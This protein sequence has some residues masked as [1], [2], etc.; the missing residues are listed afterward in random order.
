MKIFSV[1]FLFL[2]VMGCFGESGKDMFEV[3]IKDHEEAIGY[4]SKANISIEA[5][6]LS[7]KVGFRFWRLGWLTLSPSLGQLDLTEFVNNSGVTVF[8]GEIDVGPF[9]GFDLKI[10]SIQGILREGQREATITK[11]VSPV[12]LAF[13]VHPRQITTIVID[14]SVMDMSDHPPATYELQMAGYEVYSNGKLVDKV[15]PG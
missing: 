14:L 2:T 10:R 5:I 12:A 7:P 13:S 9:E 6:R 3:R 8:R 11:K 1:L 4:F 15:P